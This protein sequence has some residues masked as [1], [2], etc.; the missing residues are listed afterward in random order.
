M[1]S[2][3]E[4]Q[5]IVMSEIAWLIV[6]WTIVGSTGIALV[7]C[8]LLW[9]LLSCTGAKLLRELSLTDDAGVHCVCN[10]DPQSSCFP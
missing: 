9:V 6:K 5:R 1:G 4:R 10:P 3:P 2:E 8:F 7:F